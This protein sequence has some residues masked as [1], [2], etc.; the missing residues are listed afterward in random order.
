MKNMNELVTD[1]KDTTIVIK[2]VRIGDGGD[3]IGEFAV[4]TCQDGEE[5]LTF[6]RRVVRLAKKLTLPAKVKLWRASYL[7]A[8]AGH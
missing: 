2:A 5:Y 7:V 8:R 1:G 3:E 6:D 4:L